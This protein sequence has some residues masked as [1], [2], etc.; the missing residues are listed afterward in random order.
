MISEHENISVQRLLN[1]SVVYSRSNIILKDCPVPALPGVYVWFFKDFPSIVPSNGCIQ[2]NGL[3]ALYVGISPG[4]P[5][6]PQ[7]LRQRVRTH[8]KG[9][10]EGSTLRRTLGILQEHQS[11]FPLRRVGSGKRMTLTHLGEQWL[12]GWM[13]ENAFI[14]W[15]VHPQPWDIEHH[16][17]KQFNFPLNIQDNG[18]RPFTKEL[19]ILRQKANET[20]RE[21][22]IANE[23]NHK[24]S[25]VVIS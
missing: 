20:A 23:T 21:Q 4:S 9:N 18:H 14:N 11:G 10:A 7:N 12:D 6:S 17:L 13:Q 24:R 3:T 2:F 19:S 1:P 8:Y 22:P 16:L 25:K 5:S 15:M